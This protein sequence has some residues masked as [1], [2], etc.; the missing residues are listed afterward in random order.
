MKRYFIFSA[1]LCS[2]LSLTS[3]GLV[4]S[5]ANTAGRSV[6]SVVRTVGM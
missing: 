5:V 2:I 6:Q 1:L 3:C 4:N